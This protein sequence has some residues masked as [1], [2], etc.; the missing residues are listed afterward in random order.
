[1]GVG[2]RHS[3]LQDYQL[4]S[5]AVAPGKGRDFLF[6]GKSFVL[7]WGHGVIVWPGWLETCKVDQAG[8]NSQRSICL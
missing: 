4:S 7:F 5:A 2:L 8:L 1:M 6:G 3:G